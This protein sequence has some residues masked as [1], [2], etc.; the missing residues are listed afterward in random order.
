MRM[1][2]S[3]YKDIKFRSVTHIAVLLVLLFTLSCGG[4][5]GPDPQPGS[6]KGTVALFITD[7]ISFYKQVVMTITGIRLVNSGTG[8]VCEVLSDPVTLDIANLTNLAHY[9]NLTECPDGRYNKVSIDFQKNARLMKLIASEDTASVCTFTSYLS[10]AGE[11]KALVCGQDS[12]ICTLNIKGGIRGVP[13]TVQEDR[14]NDLG[15][16]FNLKEF[17][18]DNFGEPADCS[19]TMKAAT[20]SAYDMNSSGRSHEVSGSIQGLAAHTFTL[21]SS[22]VSLTVDYSKINQALQKN[23]YSLLLSAQSE[24]YP[25][26]VQTGGIALETGTIKAN[27]IFMKVAGTVSR[28]EDAPKWSF[29]L[30]D[31]SSKTVDASYK[32]P[33]V[34][35]GALV[36]GAWVNARFDGYDDAKTAFLAESIEVLPE[37]TVIDD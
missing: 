18:V 15:I 10:D 21:L 26:I 12:G 24:G 22:G 25:V 37:G 1:R 20:V 13:I 17:T 8:G 7:N 9:V 23:I 33:A 28:V 27:R 11:T 31:P 30:T 32:P 2:L 4:G 5:T 3:S 16:D 35:A 19:V 6:G 29:T 14:Y 36:D 34:L